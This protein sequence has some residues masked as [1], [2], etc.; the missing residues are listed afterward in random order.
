MI[1][2][3]NGK[4]KQIKNNTSLKNLIESIC[5]NPN[6]IIAEVN[7]DIIKSNI[8]DSTTLKASDSIELVTFVGGG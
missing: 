7:E 4:E 5:K 3:L 1:I 6:H 2:I 8:W